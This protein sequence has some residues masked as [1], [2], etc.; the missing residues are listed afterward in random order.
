[1]NKIKLAV[2][3][4]DGTITFKDTYLEVVSFH[5]GRP[6][7]YIAKTYLYWNVL[8]LRLSL[9]NNDRLKRN[10]VSL[11]F[12]GK[13]A[14]ELQRLGLNF[15]REVM[16]RIVY[17]DAIERIKWHQ[18]EGHQVVILTASCDF[19]LTA[20]ADKMNLSL[21]STEIEYVNNTFTGELI[22]A[23]CYGPV[24]V[25]KLREQYPEAEFEYAYGY[26]D[27]SSDLYFMS[28]MEEQHMKLFK[29]K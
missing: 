22:G 16:P 1:M 11:F 13:S 20:W 25:D 3:D 24:K 19:W 2:F 6:F 28:L 10:L 18:K 9:I 4:L 15:S 5:K 14:G 8:L 27:T 21:V 29:T 23:N 17:A 7:F 26:G 12:K